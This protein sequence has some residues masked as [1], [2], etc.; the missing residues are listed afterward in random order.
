MRTG[1]GQA[2][3]D[4]ERSGQ[5]EGNRVKIGEFGWREGV[6]VCGFVL[7]VFLFAPLR[8]FLHNTADFNI[9][10]AYLLA[11]LA[12]ISAI[13][14]AVLY[15]AGRL[16]PGV[17]S[18]AAFLGIVAFLE[19]TIFLSLARHRPFD[20]Q[21][22]D[23][24]QWR[25]LSAVE[26]GVAA[27]LGLLV[28]AWRRRQQLWHTV[29][30]GILLFHGLTLG[31][32]VVSRRAPLRAHSVNRVDAYL[33][34]GF[35]RLSRQRNVI[36]VVLDTTQGAM[37]YDIVQEDRERYSKAFDGFT[38]FTQAM[39]K[40]PSTYPS[41]PFYMSG[42]SP[43]P[44][45]DFTVA[46]PFTWDYVRQTLKE[47]SIVGALAGSG[48][49][50]FGY[51]QGALY[52]TGPYDACAAGGVF[53]GVA[54]ETDGRT[55]AILHLL[56]VAL[57][58][59][60]PVVVRRRVYNDG[61]WMLKGSRRKPRTYSAV[62]DTFLERVSADAEAPT[63]NYFHL[64]GG[65]GPVQFDQR[66]G[67][68]GV[69]ASSYANQRRQVA[70]GLVQIERLIASLRRLGVYD[71]TMIVVNGD[72]GTPGLPPSLASATG[73]VVSPYMIGTAS[74][75][76][77]VKPL[78]AR[79]PL[80]LSDA[81]ASIGDIPATLDDALGL[82]GEFPG[83]SLLRIDGAPRERHYLL[84]DDA[85]RVTGL[86]A[87][88]NLR[89]YRVRGSLFDES[90]WVRPVLSG[91]G[92]VPSALWMD[93][94]HFERHATG[95]TALEMHSKPARWVLGTRAR[96]RLSR[97][98]DGPTR[99]VLECFVPPPIT[100]GQTITVS[101]NGTVVARLDQ[102]ALEEKRRHAVPIPR[103]VSR[104]GVNTIDLEMGRAEPWGT[105]SRPVST[106]VAYLGLEPDAD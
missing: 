100:T 43:D 73:T 28:V 39:G 87:L 48:Y 29:A 37:V 105:H 96:V 7:P 17:I 46:Q 54:L 13:L 64:A 34:S 5:A 60:T 74:A 89:R 91:P 36:H 72:H 94:Q 2:P 19:S 11:G 8:V 81:P 67:Y 82:S 66:C 31:Y 95:F 23:W 106:V 62:M 35:H 32:A 90:A 59:S 38:L 25:T 56:D 63:Y 47:R 22:I 41:V 12:L 21:P 51:Q 75:L 69:Q 76:L 53:D 15:A 88:P 14:S 33:H 97:P 30:L 61:D 84:Y 20:G 83:V 10:L 92:E 102:K 24:S 6:I 4:R 1:D 57:F 18:L 99:F 101:V 52:C 93:D 86:Q 65:H 27:A 80:A 26:L 40:Y 55:S 3:A 68:V 58:Q 85:E 16:W 77:M 71:E 9:G 78:G 50:T 44:E 98:A 45:R 49:R 42:L 103:A 104:R 79:A 70:C